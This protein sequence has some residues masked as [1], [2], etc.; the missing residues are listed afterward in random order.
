M[1]STTNDHSFSPSWN[2]FIQDKMSES[3]GSND[4]SHADGEVSSTKQTHK[5]LYAYG[6]VSSTK[7]THKELY[8]E[9]AESTEK[10]ASTAEQQSR[11]KSYSFGRGL[12]A[13]WA[14]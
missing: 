5:E 8:L 3:C 9:E 10:M 2:E 6:E 13:R 12:N 14:W 1:N 7:R 4:F 11:S